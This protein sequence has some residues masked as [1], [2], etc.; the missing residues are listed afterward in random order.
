MGRYRD[1]AHALVKYGFQDIAGRL[2]LLGL[3]PQRQ[4]PGKR[5]ADGLTT[6][7]RVRLMLE[8]LGPTFIKLG[9]VLSTRPDILPPEYIAELAKLQDA[10]PP[11]PWRAIKA[12][13]EG[14]LGQPL[15]A[16]FALVET[17]PLGSASLA[18]VH[19][20][21]LLDS[22]D[23]VVKVQRP[24]IERTIDIDLEIL[25]DLASL[26][27]NRTTLGEFVDLPEVAEEFGYTLHTELD[28]EREAGSADRFRHNFADEPNLYIP[29]IYWDYVT[30]RVLVME[31]L[32][33]IKIDNIPALRQA[34]YDPV[35]V[36]EKASNMIVREVLIDGFFHADPHPGNLIVMEGE[37]IG[38]MDFGMVGWLEPQQR[39][40]LVQLYIAAIRIDGDAMVTHLI[41]LGATSQSVD[42]SQLQRDISRLVRKYQGRALRQIYVQEL[43]ND[44][45]TIAFKHHLRLP[46]D[47]W[48]LAKAL[49]VMEGVGQK[50]DPDFDVFA[51]SEPYIRQLQ[52]EMLL[53]KTWGPPLLKALGEWADLFSVMP[54]AGGEFLRRLE[55]DEVTLHVEPQG[56][57]P[58]LDRLEAI[59]DRLVAGMVVAALIV[60]L[61]TLA[62]AAGA[63]WMMGLFAAGLV[64]VC[65]LGLWLLLAILRR[66]R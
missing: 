45:M 4:R 18:Q 38:G 2:G 64:G 56:M 11:A 22:T 13:I 66:R 52:R 32:Y 44:V 14:E 63:S 42:R 46:S 23:V 28:Y 50:L 15:D 39:Y 54:H 34:G 7:A 36:I 33:G 59:G 12:C 21:R 55:R 8:E 53:P 19:G 31:R 47:L 60:A 57:D 29:R 27:Q 17:E 16:V 9:Q 3:L 25:Y 26:V 30:R 20:A 58:V 49:T 35:R 65:A 41:R 5:P 10:V 24:G 6:P 62:A 61:A 48:L 51:A 43:L 40:E 1:I 37:V